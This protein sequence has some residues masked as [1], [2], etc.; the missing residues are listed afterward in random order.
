MKT[1][2]TRL[3]AAQLGFATFA[4]AP[5]AQP[6]QPAAQDTLRTVSI[7]DGFTFQTSQAVTAE[8][9]APGIDVTTPVVIMTVSGDVIV[10]GA[11][12]P[13][14][15]FVTRF[16]LPTKDQQVRIV[17]APGRAEQDLVF[18]TVHAGRLVHSFNQ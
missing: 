6:E 13:H 3:L 17:F 9:S 8:L 14:E 7:P 2:M 10:R 4:C 15:P 16:A 11:I 12:S 18:A 1:L 5:D